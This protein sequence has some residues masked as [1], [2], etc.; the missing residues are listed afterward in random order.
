MKHYIRLFVSALFA[1]MSM[2]SLAVDYYVAPGGSDN[3]PGTFSAPFATVMAAHAAASSG[4]SVYLRGGTYQLDNSHISTLTPVRAIVNQITKNGIRYQAYAGERPVF[5]FSKVRPPEHRVVAFLVS[6]DDN[7]FVGFDI[8]GVQITIADKHT[9]STAIRVDNGDRNRFEHLAIHDNMAIGWYLASG[10]DNLVLNVDAYNNKGLNA[11]SH[12]NIDGFGAHPKPSG[13]GNILRG[14]RAW[15]NSD[16]G[17]DFIRAAKAVT[18]ENSWAF[19]NGYDSDFTE[20]GDGNGFKAG[21]YGRS[22]EQYP[23]PVPRHV[24]RHCL[25]VRN[26]VSGFYAN[27]HIGGQDWINNTAIANPYNYNMLSTLADNKTDAPGYGHFMRNNLGYD[28]AEE[29]VHLGD[30]SDNDLGAN[31]FN[32]PVSV[33]TD[34]FVSLDERLLTRPRKPNGELPDIDFARLAPGSD[35]IDAGVDTGL[36]FNGSAPDLGAFESTMPDVV[37]EQGKLLYSADMASPQSVSGWIMEGPGKVVFDQGWMEMFSPDEAMHHVY[38]CPQT[39]PASFIARWQAQNL[40]L[41]AGLVIVFLAAA[42]EKGEDIFDPGLPARDG[43]FS[44]YTEGKIRSYHISYY[45]NAAHN[46]D[47]GH[48]NLRKNNTFSL[49]QQ[50]SVG[51]P[52]R[53]TEPHQITL[54]KEGARIRLFVDERKVIDYIDDRPVVEGVDTGPA[55]GAGKIGFRQMQWTRFRYRDFRVYTIAD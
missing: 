46:P 26:R 38:W 28:G 1:A 40:K 16:D 33:S 30:K 54:V 29:V 50:G 10:S 51:I 24:I 31:Y 39:F 4:D 55:F 52:T 27:H 11:H 35:L 47:R 9:Q 25:A 13:S 23:T 14:C 32:L 19:Y 42:G 6:G 36:P 34:D 20:L 15:F 8:T 45:A 44:Q 3:N 21:G 17:F 41:D 43:T 7:A 53:S 48:A 37:P 2:H 22:G 12:G 18:V 5:D 49:L